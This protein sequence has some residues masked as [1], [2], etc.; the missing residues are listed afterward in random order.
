MLLTSVVYFVVMRRTWKWPLPVAL[1]IL[2]FFLS[3]DVPFL[4]ANAVKI[5]DGGWVPISIGAV[6]VAGMLI[7]S[8]GRA[9]IVRR[10]TRRFSALAEGLPRLVRNEVVRVPGT[11]VFLAS[12][13]HHIPPILVQLVDRGCALHE[14]VCLLTVITEPIPSVPRSRRVELQ[15]LEHGF[16]RL[17]ARYG[18]MEHP[19]V[20]AL[21]RAAALDLSL[22]SDPRE[23]TYFLG[24]ESLLTTD[25]G[26]MGRFAETLYAF[27]SRNA[28]PVDR[29]FKIPPEQVIEIGI[30]LDL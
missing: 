7:W 20:P 25:A 21:L 26:A 19:D 23:I 10:F 29:L 12:S 22:P 4:L 11:A 27:L 28:V 15:R 6:F 24:R 30:Q 1:L 13:A 18:F 3:F 17:I 8:K 5:L 16:S 2:V 14:H 9:L